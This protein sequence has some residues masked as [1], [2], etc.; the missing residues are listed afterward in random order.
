MVCNTDT[1]RIG[2]SKLGGLPDL[3]SGTKWPTRAA[4]SCSRKTYSYLPDVAWAPAPLHFLAQIN[5]ADVA[6]A[7][8]DLPLPGDGTLL[9]FY[10]AD[11]Q[12]WGMYPHDSVGTC[13]LFA[14]AGQTLERTYGPN[15]S[16]ATQPLKF[17]PGEGL[18]GWEWIEQKMREEPGCGRD[19]IFYAS[20]CLDDETEKMS[21][22][23]HRFGGWPSLIQ[24]PMELEC[25]LASNGI[26][27]GHPAD[28][29]VSELEKGV[30]DWRLLLQLKSDE[31]LGWIWGDV[32][33]IYFWC[34]EEDIA[35]CRFDRIWTVLQC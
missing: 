33:M 10:D 14:E 25:Q 29:R 5:L 2:A 34:R 23:G 12:P 3:S 9:F 11:V 20:G 31:N 16:A 15:A 30:E 13:V 17:A 27:P 21:W 7:G 19:E 18:P 28:E 8:C 32:G 24:A 22:G 35:A 4:Y 1:T 26:I 6:S